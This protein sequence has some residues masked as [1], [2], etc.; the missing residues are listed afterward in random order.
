MM[1]SGVH[2]LSQNKRSNCFLIDE[3]FYERDNEYYYPSRL[4]ACKRTVYARREDRAKSF[5]RPYFDMMYLGVWINYLSYNIPIPVVSL[6][7]INQLI[8]VNDYDFAHHEY[9]A[10]NFLHERTVCSRQHE[11]R[12]SSFCIATS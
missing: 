9:K 2:D 3:Y 4:L 5:E 10:L 8:N 6:K 12:V 11:S 1:K 7:K